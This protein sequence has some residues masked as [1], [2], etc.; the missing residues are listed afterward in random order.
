VTRR[1]G[2]SGIEVIHGVGGGT[3]EPLEGLAATRASHDAGAF[4]REL[5][6]DGQ[7]DAV[8]AP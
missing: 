6:G 2:P 1:D 5:A 4:G 7:R 3:I 8:L